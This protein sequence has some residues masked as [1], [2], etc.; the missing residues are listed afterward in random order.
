[1]T[2]R[3]LIGKMVKMSPKL[4]ELL[5]AGGSEEHLREF[6]DCIGEVEGFVDFNNQGENDPS[7]V[8]P[9]AEVRWRP[10]MLRYGYLP[11]LLDLV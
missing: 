5:L 9:E 8:G 3:N 2:T 6:G 4:K 10:S 11:E 1:M 7:K